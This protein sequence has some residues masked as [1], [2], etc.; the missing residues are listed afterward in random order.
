LNEIHIPRV[1]G[2]AEISVVF[3]DTSHQLF[4]RLFFFISVRYIGF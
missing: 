3:I 4:S 2:I 1:F